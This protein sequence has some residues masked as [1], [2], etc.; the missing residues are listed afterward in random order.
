M[1]EYLAFWSERVILIEILVA[2]VLYKK[3][4]LAIFLMLYV[5]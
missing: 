4:F 2:K 3:D 1:S 5:R